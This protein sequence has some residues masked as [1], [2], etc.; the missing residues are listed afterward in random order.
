MLY[1]CYS[2][3]RGAWGP[4]RAAT[5]LGAACKNNNNDNNI[6]SSNYTT[7][8]TTNNNNN[9]NN[10]NKTIN[11]VVVIMTILIHMAGR[12]LRS[13]EELHGA[14]SIILYCP[15]LSY[16]ILYYTI[17]Y[18]PILYYPIISF[19]IL[20][21]NNADYTCTAP[22]REGSVASSLRAQVNTPA[23]STTNE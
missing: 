4:A 1:I 9:N 19:T 11:I 5:K 21:Y 18:Y 10:D 20:F 2:Q 22:G 16:N 13:R 8:T 23:P 7:T 17:L 3:S 12:R 15:I 14:Y 6:N